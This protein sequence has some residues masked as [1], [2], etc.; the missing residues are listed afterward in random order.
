MKTGHIYFHL[1]NQLTTRKI[2]KLNAAFVEF[3]RNIPECRVFF[4]SICLIKLFCDPFPGAFH[5]R[6]RFTEALVPFFKGS[7][8]IP[9][10]S[11][12][13]AG[14]EMRQISC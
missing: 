5:F 10:G 8:N 4:L 7:V 14:M 13:N 3:R 12:P 9:D 6:N 2:G 1:S 11:A